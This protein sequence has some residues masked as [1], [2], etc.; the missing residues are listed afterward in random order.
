VGLIE[1]HDGERAEQFWSKH[2]AEVGKRL[3]D[4]DDEL[5]LIELLD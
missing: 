1:R 4:S 2:M 5:S 3:L